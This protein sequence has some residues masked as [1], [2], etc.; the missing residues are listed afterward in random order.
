M[1]IPL[2]QSC[3]DATDDKCSMTT[4]RSTTVTN[5]FSFSLGGS[6]GNKRRDLEPRGNSPAVE[7]LKAAFNFGA[8][9]SFS[10]SV[11]NITSVSFTKPKNAAGFCGYWTFVPIYVM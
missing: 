10:E 3:D 7:I 5:E 6:S 9:W 2:G 8:T 11:T 1:E 4:T